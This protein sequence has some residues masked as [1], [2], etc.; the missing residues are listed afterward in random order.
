[1][2]EKILIK[3]EKVNLK[4]LFIIVYSILLIAILGNLILNTIQYIKYK[5]GQDVAIEMI[6]KSGFD[7]IQNTRKKTITSMRNALNPSSFSVDTKYG[8]IDNGDIIEVF[9][10]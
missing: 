4:K 9:D 10:K 7:E 1:M 5:E 6:D 2:E 3:S 8:K